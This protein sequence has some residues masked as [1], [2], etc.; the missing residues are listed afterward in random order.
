MRMAPHVVLRRCDRQDHNSRPLPQLGRL[1]VRG[2][3]AALSG[4]AMRLIRALT[5]VA[6]TN[7]CSGVL[8]VDADPC[9]RV[10]CPTDQH[11]EAGTCVDGPANVT[12]DNCNPLTPDGDCPPP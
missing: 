9:K 11:C 10:T 8:T 2:E 7:A 4:V 1:N 3:R 5:L 6:L 12:H